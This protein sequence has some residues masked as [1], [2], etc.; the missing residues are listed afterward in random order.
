MTWSQWITPA[1]DVYVPAVRQISAGRVV[2]EDFAIGD[3]NVAAVIESYRELL[4]A[5][6][7]ISVGINNLTAIAAA[8]A[9]ASKDSAPSTS[10]YLFEAQGVL[11]LQGSQYADTFDWLPAEL[12][13]LQRGVDYDVR[14]DRQPSDDDAY[15]QYEFEHTTFLGWQDWTLVATYTTVTPSGSDHPVGP[16]W[17]GDGFS[18]RVAWSPALSATLSEGPWYEYGHGS[19]LTSVDIPVSLEF[20][21]STPFA[22]HASIEV[23]LSTVDQADLTLLTQPSFLDATS[24]PEPTSDITAGQTFAAGF[25][26]NLVQGFVRPSV[27]YQRPRWRYWIPDAQYA[28]SALD[29]IFYSRSGNDGA[30]WSDASRVIRR[31]PGTTPSEGGQTIHD[32]FYLNGLSAVHT[33]DNLILVAV[34]HHNIIGGYGVDADFW[35]SPP[36]SGARAAV[37]VLNYQPAGTSAPVGSDVIFKGTRTRL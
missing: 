11:Q 6:G 15:V 3:R 37:A 20:G 25:E 32:S 28:D 18:L 26:L 7:G 17:T 4:A 9:Q 36:E 29:N 22:S 13:A 12:A 27:S 1:P 21:S 16:P 8:S 23:P 34:E 31:S 24:A 30:R 5:G 35:Q 33:D 10:T 14:P 2:N 19:P